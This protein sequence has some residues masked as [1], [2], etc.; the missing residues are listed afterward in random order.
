MFS[1]TRGNKFRT[2][3]QGAS[4]NLIRLRFRS[5]IPT[6]LGKVDTQLHTQT[7]HYT[8]AV[9]LPHTRSHSSQH[10]ANA[11]HTS[12]LC[13]V[14]TVALFGQC[15][16]S[17]LPTLSSKILRGRFLKRLPIDACRRY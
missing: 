6:Y 5:K 2:Y 7:K 9:N 11:S 8:I 10:R 1:I 4:R 14:F 16:L 13:L 3:P 12:D 15:L 17:C